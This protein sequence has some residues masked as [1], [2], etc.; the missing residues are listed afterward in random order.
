[1]EALENN[2]VSGRL[3]T[4][5]RK[6]RGTGSSSRLSSAYISGGCS[7][8]SQI[9]PCAQW[10][11]NSA[12]LPNTMLDSVAATCDA[13]DILRAKHRVLIS[14]GESRLS[15]ELTSQAACHSLPFEG[16]PRQTCNMSSC[17]IPTTHTGM[18]PQQD[19]LH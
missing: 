7:P 13:Q 10:Y 19:P 14:S 2:H 17:G 8:A 5:N 18:Q 16:C 11:A 9:W 1:M 12:A 3:P 4:W 6:R 15:E